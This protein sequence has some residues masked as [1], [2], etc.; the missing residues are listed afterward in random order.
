MAEIEME[1]KNGRNPWLWIAAAA[2]VVVLAVGAWFL[3]GQ[4]ATG[5]ETDP[6]A[7]QPGVTEP[8]GADPYGAD[9]DPYG[10][11]PYGADPTR[12]DA[13]T[14]DPYPGQDGTPD[15]SERQPDERDPLNT[16]EETRRP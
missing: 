16:P 3:L 1:R 11:D 15:D 10:T 13:G 12:P 4:D 9:P 5:Y 6:A 14:A 7:E 2:L 8:Y